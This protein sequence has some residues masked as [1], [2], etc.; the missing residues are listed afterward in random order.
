MRGY[1]IKKDGDTFYFELLPSNNNNQPIG[2]SKEYRS[3]KDCIEAI[4]EFRK[5]IEKNNINSL[6]SK[7]AIYKK[8]IGKR[9]FLI[10]FDNEILYMSR[11]YTTH[12][13]DNCNRSLNDIYKHIEK[14]TTNDKGE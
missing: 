10:H 11:F 12:F 4:G 14:Y 5:I 13:K 3:K 1:K 2:R 9:H 8:E 6:S 7:Y